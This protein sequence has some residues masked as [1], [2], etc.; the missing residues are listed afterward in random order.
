MIDYGHSDPN[1]NR[2]RIPPG[3]DV[4]YMVLDRASLKR[5][6]KALL[7]TA[8]V[9]PYLF[10]LL[11]LGITLLIGLLD[12][13]V[14]MDEDF[15]YMYSMRLGMD[16]SFLALHR[17]F[18]TLVVL[19]VTVVCALLQTVLSAGE[20]LYHLGIRRSENMP[21]V[22][23]FDGFAFAGKLILLAIVQYIFIFLWTLLLVIPGIVAAYR[24]RFAVLNLCENPDIGI[25][26]AINMSKAQ[27]RGFK[28]QLFVLDLSF[29]G[30]NLLVGL[31]LGILSIWI[32]PYQL[33]SNVAFFQKI[34]EFKGV[35]FLPPRP[36]EDGQF[37]PNDPFG[38]NFQ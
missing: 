7:K 6:S 26:E 12:N 37:R 9:N 34:K 20:W 17:P 11:V 33:Q 36:E 8:Q 22:T 1:M 28:W 27:T 23:L 30:W 10:T 14:S 19:F 3:K 4:N 15:A 21:Y 31:T 2:R 13:Y 18:P 29:I 32:R 25:M 35:G 5:D 24:Y 16:V 38:G